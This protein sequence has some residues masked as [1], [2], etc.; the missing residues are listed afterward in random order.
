MQ[1]ITRRS[2]I[3]LS[4]LYTLKGSLSHPRP[5]VLF[6]LEVKVA[7]K[8]KLNDEWK[9]N[10]QKFAGL[11]REREREREREK[12]RER[13]RLEKSER[14][15]G[16]DEGSNKPN[17]QTSLVIVL[18]KL[19]P[20]PI[21]AFHNCNS[22]PLAPIRAFISFYYLKSSMVWG[23]TSVS[24]REKEVIVASVWRN[25]IISKLKIGSN[26]TNVAK[27]DWMI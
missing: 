2:L 12:E 4:L 23:S 22:L 5:H 18:N 15:K 17:R 16:G 27:A 8:N 20:L 13:Q 14:K 24:D 7:L 21:L 1:K 25:E 6:Q 10:W 11:Q 9:L 26:L 19:S 3:N